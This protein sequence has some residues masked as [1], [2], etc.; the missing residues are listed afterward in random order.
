M[1]NLVQFSV[2]QLGVVFGGIA[3]VFALLLGLLGLQF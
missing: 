1:E 3:C 2:D